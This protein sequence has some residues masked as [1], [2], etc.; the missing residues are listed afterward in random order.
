M[1]ILDLQGALD[2]LG[3]LEKQLVMALLQ[4]EVTAGNALIGAVGKMIRGEVANFFEEFDKRFS[5]KIGK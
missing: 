2:R 5:L 4:G 3:P 1:D